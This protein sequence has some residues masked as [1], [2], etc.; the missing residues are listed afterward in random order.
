MR[1][2]NFSVHKFNVLNNNNDEQT[3][4]HFNGE[5][6]FLDFLEKF[7]NDI[8]KNIRKSSDNQGNTSILS[9]KVPGIK[10]NDDN[11][12]ISGYL[13]LGVSGKDFSIKD[14]ETN[15]VNYLVKKN[16][17]LSRELYF[18]A[19]IPRGKNFGIILLE[20]KEQ[21]G[22]IKLF[23]D[24]INIFFSSQ[25][26]SNYKL[27]INQMPIEIFIKD[28]LKYG[29]LKEINCI[30]NHIP[31]DIKKQNSDIR[32]YDGK[33]INTFKIPEK[34]ENY[35]DFIIKLYN[36][37]FLDYEKINIDEDGYDEVTFLIRN[38]NQEKTFYIKDKD[39]IKSDMKLEIDDQ[40]YSS[41]DEMYFTEFLKI[42]NKFIFP[43][44]EK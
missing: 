21:Y 17:N 10:R 5:N 35:K 23:T 18:M 20:K 24:N 7:F 26:Y 19:C 42:I 6:D 25:G 31:N 32:L 33:Q 14:N 4:S 8:L 40:E 43:N 28:F 11:R 39:K 22:L 16:E 15:N 44:K 27:K 37:K 1:N 34:N 2:I 41:I 38:K 9:L 13:D 29:T 30:K 36:S 3:L 12:I